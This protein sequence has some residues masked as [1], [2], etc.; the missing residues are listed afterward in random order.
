MVD[1]FLTAGLTLVVFG[2]FTAL[3]HFR[4]RAPPR[5]PGSTLTPFAAPPESI[6]RCVELA[7]G[8]VLFFPWRCALFFL[9]L[10]LAWF[11][12]VLK[13]MFKTRKA[14][15]LWRGLM[16]KAARIIAF[17]LGTW[18]IETTG[19]PVSYQEAPIIVAN[20]TGF[21][22]SVI[23]FAF[24]LPSVVMAKEYEK[25]W[26]VG[27]IVKSLNAIPVDRTN[28]D[29]RKAVSVAIQTRATQT[30]WQNQTQVLVFPEGTTS[31]GSCLLQFKLG[32]F[33]P[34]LPVQPVAVHFPFWQPCWV[35]GGSSLGGLFFKLMASFWT[36]TQV[37]F[38]PIIGP[39][40]TNKKEEFAHEA[41]R[42]M[43]QA[44]KCPITNYSHVDVNMVETVQMLTTKYKLSK[45]S[46]HNVLRGIEFESARLS[47]P[48]LTPEIATTLLHNFFQFCGRDGWF[49]RLE[50]LNPYYKKGFIRV[51]CLDSED[52]K[53]KISFYNFLAAFVSLSRADLSSNIWNTVLHVNSDPRLPLEHDKL[54]FSE[55]DIDKWILSAPPSTSKSEITFKNNV[56]SCLFIPI[57]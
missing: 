9:G 12:A 26:I 54:L 45:S 31:N 56:L 50:K 10:F 13:P 36:R 40:D 5:M 46:S 39:C 30:E 35:S 21:M 14:H 41:R 44:L 37:T 33:A 19:S 23:L 57:N 8:S 29:S 15:G 48:A 32:A 49:I 17:A 2:V 43:A 24:F 20:H 38:L 28:A 6:W 22:D 53:A 16:K 3:M 1:F 18:W 51:L 11:F 34:G 27:T 4:I 55:S 42:R 52:M 47:C 25:F 7:L